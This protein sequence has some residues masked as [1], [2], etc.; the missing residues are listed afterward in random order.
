M[1]RNAS[2]AAIELTM[3]HGSSDTPGVSARNAVVCPNGALDFDDPQTWTGSIDRSPCGT[4][5]CG[6]MAAKHARGEL[7]LHA[8]FVHES[9]LGTQ[10]TGRLEEVVTGHAND[11]VRP[12]IAGQ[13]WVTGMGHLLLDDSDP[14]SEGYTLADIW[15]P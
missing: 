13:A 9:I 3:L 10:F 15:A 11:A 5:T 14:F 7:D 2:S 12:V 1:V 8:P 6:R 4:G